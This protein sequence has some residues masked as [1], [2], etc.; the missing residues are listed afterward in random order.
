MTVTPGQ[1]GFEEGYRVLGESPNMFERHGIRSTVVCSG[2]G[3]WEEHEM[4][5]QHMVVVSAPKLAN[6]V[7]AQNFLSGG[8]RFC[9]ER[10]D[11]IPS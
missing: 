3:I 5:V 11:T 1:F 4:F 9:N 10:E 6:M 7:R 2:C 8:N